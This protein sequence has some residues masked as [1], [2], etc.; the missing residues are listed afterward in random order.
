LLVERRSDRL[1]S[2]GSLAFT[3]NRGD[4]VLLV[5]PG[6]SGARIGISG[7]F[8]PPPDATYEDPWHVTYGKRSLTRKAALRLRAEHVV[9]AASD[10]IY[11]L[12][13]PTPR[14]PDQGVIWFDVRPNGFTRSPS[15]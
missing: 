5:R 8:R 1:A 12:M 13:T 6:S 4:S 10:H 15:R 11:P 9:A 7:P 2:L 3:S 14:L